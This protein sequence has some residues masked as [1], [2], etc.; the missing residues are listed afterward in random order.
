MATIIRTALQLQA[1]SGDLTADYELGSDIDCTGMAAW[2]GGLGFVPVGTYTLGVPADAFSGSFDGKNYKIID[3]S[4]TR[5]LLDHIGLFGYTLA[6]GEIKNVT[7]EDCTISGDYAVGPLVAFV[8]VGSGKISNC[9]STGTVAG[10]MLAG[11]LIGYNLS[12]LEDCHSDCVCT[13]A[14]TGIDDAVQCGGL[15]GLDVT[16][17]GVTRCYATGDITV[18]SDDDVHEIG[19]FAGYSVNKLFSECFASGDISVTAGGQGYSIG[20]FIG[21]CG[22]VDGI[23]NSFS[24]GD[25]VVVVVDNSKGWVGGFIGQ[26]NGAIM[27][28]CYSAGLVD[29]TAGQPD[30]GGFCGE[31]IGG[32]FND[33]F[34]DTQT[35]GQAASDGGTGKTTA[36]MKSSD[37]FSAVGWPL[38]TIWYVLSGC[39]N[40][41]P[42]LINVQAC[43]Q[44]PPADETIV[45][46]KVTLEAIRNIE[47]VYG[48]RFYIDKSGNAVYESRYHRNV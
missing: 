43:C 33:C 24:T 18:T 9:H 6:S 15:I 27:E 32:T 10:R 2:N 29:E 8:G 39:N 28:N 47:F 45:G 12:E 23:Y 40:G 38:S 7:F 44:P 30:I 20:G 35:S 48:G 42:C 14:A 4:C 21:S 26:N 46:D 1:M 34:W 36:Q 5:P 11:G 13:F 17:V 16:A 37:T 3:F 22:G 41:Y 31:D 25:V 19:G